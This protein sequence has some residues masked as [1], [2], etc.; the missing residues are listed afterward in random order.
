[1]AIP[2]DADDRSAI[3]AGI[4]R[5]PADSGHCAAL[6]RVV[7]RVALPRDERTRGLSIRP[8]GAARFLAVRKPLRKQWA[9]HVLVETQE[10]RVDALTGADG[11]PASDYLAEHFWFPERLA[12]HEVDVS[13]IDTWIQQEEQ[14]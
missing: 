5:Y 6:A 2:W 10:H 3:E 12:V 1:V 14:A 11:C 13:T 9:A 4:A 8:A 7:H